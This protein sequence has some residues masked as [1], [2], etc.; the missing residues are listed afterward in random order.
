MTMQ[1]RRELNLLCRNCDHWARRKGLCDRCSKH[2]EKTFAVQSTH[3]NENKHASD[4]VVGYHAVAATA[5]PKDNENIGNKPA[6]N[7]GRSYKKRKRTASDNNI[8]MDAPL[9]KRRHRRSV[10][11]LRARAVQRAEEVVAEARAGLEA[12]KKEIKKA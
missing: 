4:N 12:A 11:E 10:V 9:R 3:S 5:E 2:T 6:T 7:I 1:E 8:C